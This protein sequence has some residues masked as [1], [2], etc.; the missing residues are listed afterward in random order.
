MMPLNAINHE[1]DV[2]GLLPHTPRA[3]HTTSII[4]GATYG[5]RVRVRTCVHGGGGGGIVDN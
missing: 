2:L 5:R 4:R 1:L 3:T